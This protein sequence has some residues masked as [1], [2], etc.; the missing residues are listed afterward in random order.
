MPT[1]TNKILVVVRG[2]VVTNVFTSAGTEAV[3]IFD[4]DNLRE[5]LLGAE[6]EDRYSAA[7]VELKAAY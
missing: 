1:P 5:E 4:V 2:G 7:T 3:E 6:I